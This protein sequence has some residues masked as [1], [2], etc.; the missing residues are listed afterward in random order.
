[1]V[2]RVPEAVRELSDKLRN[3][4]FFRSTCSTGEA[5]H[6]RLEEVKSRYS[7]GQCKRCGAERQFDNL[8]PEILGYY[9]IVRSE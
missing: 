2:N 8:E 4:T 7:N 5:H 9:A 3:P 6:R 1:M